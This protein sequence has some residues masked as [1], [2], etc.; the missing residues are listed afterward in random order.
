METLQGHSWS[1]TVDWTLNKHTIVETVE[2]GICIGCG[3][4][5]VAT[6]GAIRLRLGRHRL[7]QPDLVGATEAQLA[8]ASRV[9][10][11]S[12]DALTEDELGAPSIAGRELR[13]DAR[14]GRISRTFAGR[15][16][17]EADIVGASSG[18]LTTW[19]LTKLLKRGLVDGIVHV[20]PAPAAGAGSHYEYVVS[21]G[22]EELSARRKS[23]YAP[24]HLV[25]VMSK[26][27]GDGRRYAVV[28]VPCFIKACR[29]LA[30]E[31]SVLGEQVA[32]YVGLV[33][34]HLKSEFFGESL[35]WQLGIS[36][37]DLA[38]VDFRVKV[39]GRPSS[40]YNFGARKVG[41][42]RWI[43]LPTASLVGG[44]WGHAAMQPEACNFCDDIFAETADA[45][46]GDAWLPRYVANWRGT[47]VVVTRNPEL[48]AIF[49]AGLARGEIAIESLSADE[50]ARSQAGNFR[51]RREGLAVRLAD[52]L[53]LGLSVP[54]KRVQPGRRHVTSRRLKLIR[55]RR[56]IS[57]L[58]LETFAHA[59]KSGNL[60]EY[61][62]PM[63]AAVRSYRA[64]EGRLM[65][66]VFQRLARAWA[67]ARRRGPSAG[68]DNGAPS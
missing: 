17:S 31:D 49:D 3:A 7:Y 36:P 59:R 50:V 67:A 34:G 55:Q 58:S 25:S 8:V 11:F 53:E 37:S 48:D 22:E 41:Q 10:P 28:G 6:N 23:Q 57:R 27:R 32:F 35:A 1:G 54:K 12:D 60:G 64:S 16:E 42:D 52:D 21:Y 15:I 43:E 56:S 47:N 13:D 61:L 46:F 26:I 14:I 68:R 63:R 30:E 39:P 19:L 33:C 38:A 18:G 2:R 40:Q 44:N 51:H 9:C 66:R 29:L 5:S 65:R 20:A 24:T 62:R 4:C 45:V